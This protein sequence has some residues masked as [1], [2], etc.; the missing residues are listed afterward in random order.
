MAMTHSETDPPRLLVRRQATLDEALQ[1][2]ADII[3]TDGVGAVTVSEIARRMGMKA[4]SLYK[5]FPSRNAI[6]DALFARGSASLTAYVDDALAGLDPGL[7]RLFEGSRAVLRWTV[8]NT[9]LAQ[10]MFWRPVPG[11]VP[12]EA[13]FAPSQ[14][15]W[16]RF[17][18]DLAAA[19]RRRELAPA[20]DSDDAM[21]MLTV[22]IGGVGSQQMANDPGAPFDA[23][24]FTRLTDQVLAM[25][26][27]HYAPSR[28]G[29]A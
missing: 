11:F 2:A 12:S 8:A 13:S 1:H 10:L 4:P 24:A 16:Q 6:Y 15:L 26:A 21:R 7:E 9:G 19:V 29:R 28:R 25:F 18:D 20:A 3:A 14:A 23:G 22:V 17:R 5:Y 27:S